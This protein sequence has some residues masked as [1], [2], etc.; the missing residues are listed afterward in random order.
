M[1]V[2]SVAIALAA[3]TRSQERQPVAI[4]TPP[5]EGARGTPT[6][7]VAPVVPPVPTACL[8]NLTF[9]EDLTVPD[10]T[11]V[12]PGDEVDKRWSVQ[13]S[14]TCDWGEGYRLVPLDKGVFAGPEQVALF[15]ARIGESATL[16]VV[17]QAPAEPGAYTSRWQAE[18]ALGELFGEVVYLLVI[19]EPATATPE[20]TPIPG[21]S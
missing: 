12:G 14:G 16:Q 19:V 11:V 15:P 17:L 21:S 6:V 18:S 8:N 20:P 1:M 13:N 7:P 2:L 5:P 10:G 9:V 3:C 4:W